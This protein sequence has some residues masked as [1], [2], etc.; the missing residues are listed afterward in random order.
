ME[1]TQ[2]NFI[3]NLKKRMK[4]WDKI[5]QRL[6]KSL[7]LKI[8]LIISKIV[9][10]NLQDLDLKRMKN[11]K[12]MYRVRHSKFRIIFIKEGDRNIIISFKARGDS[13]KNSPNMLGER[14]VPTL[15]D[16]KIV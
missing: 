11:S 3:R 5:I 7:R 1:S 10:N 2:K 16:K 9:S 13:Y 12:N 8:L 15:E 14:L 6:P 4:D